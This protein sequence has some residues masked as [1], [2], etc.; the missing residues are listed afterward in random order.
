MA[1]EK[2]AGKLR[3]KLIMNL[4]IALAVNNKKKD[5]HADGDIITRN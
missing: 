1:E 4:N 3:G 5:R 2:R